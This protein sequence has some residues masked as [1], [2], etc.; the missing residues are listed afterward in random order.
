MIAGTG[1]G[2]DPL[3][4]VGA[5]LS[6]AAQRAQTVFARCACS[7]AASLFPIGKNNSGSQSTQ[8]ARV[9]QSGGHP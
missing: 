9:S 4:D 8:A 2:V 6:A 3:D 1:R 7:T 5:T